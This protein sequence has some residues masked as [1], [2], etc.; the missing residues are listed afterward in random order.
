MARV[1]YA[2]VVDCTEES[3]ATM[4]VMEKLAELLRN[5]HHPA[6]RVVTVQTLVPMAE[7]QR[8]QSPERT[9]AVVRFEDT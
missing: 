9:S 4:D 1:V 5:R 3:E 6:I 2:V 7:D 8:A